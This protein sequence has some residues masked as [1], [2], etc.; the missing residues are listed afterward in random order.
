MKTGKLIKFLW[1]VALIS[2]VFVNF[3]FLAQAATPS[4]SEVSSVEITFFHS[5]TC[6][7]CAKEAVFLDKLQADYPSISIIRYEIKEQKSLD[8]LKDFYQNYDVPQSSQG[9]VPLTFIGDQ[10]Y[11][12]FSEDTKSKMLSQ[13]SALLEGGVGLTGGSGNGIIDQTDE[14][15]NRKFKIPFLK[16]FDLAGFSPLALSAAVG[17]LDGFNACAMI[18]LGVLL[19]ILVTTGIRKRVVIIGGTFILVSG[20]VYYIFIAAWLNVFLFL[21]YIK[22]ITYIV[23]VVIILFALFLLKDYFNN[24]ICKVCRV[25]NKDDSALVR[26]QRYLFRRA[27]KTVSSDMPLIWMVLGVAVI[28]A[29]INMVE[30]FCSLGFPLAYTKILTTYNLPTYQY[31][32]YLLVYV[33][34]YMID[35]FLIFLVA[36]FTLRITGVSEKYLKFIKLISAI[37][38][39]ILGFIMLFKPELLTF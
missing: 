14:F 9:L 8:K 3:S 27:N 11:L 18:A 39:L 20:L 2:V 15:S 16:E 32:L 29:G 6:P 36:V 34:F 13:I 24:I 28:A 10:V 12:G 37:V 33:T 38:L 21:G 1:S 23:S 4:A 22:I 30:L 31:Y 35:D 26:F 7:V 25:D 17:I 5:I 19:A